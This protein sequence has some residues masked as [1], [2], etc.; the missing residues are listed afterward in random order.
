MTLSV[1]IFAITANAQYNIGTSTTVTDFMGNKTTTHRNEYGQIT[2]SSTSS[3]D[4]LG[5]TTTT[6]SDR[7]GKT[8]GHSYMKLLWMT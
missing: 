7:N 2:G 5:Y 3:T 1:V 4:F 6:H 8:I